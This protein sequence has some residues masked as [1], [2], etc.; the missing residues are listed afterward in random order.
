[1]KNFILLLVLLTIAINQSI[2]QKSKFGKVTKEEL[3]A[4]SH[5]LEEDAKAAIL[6]QEGNH[7]MEYNKSKKQF[8][9]ITEVYKKI[10]IY[11]ATDDSYA[12]VNVSLYTPSKDE[13]NVSSIKAVTYNLEADKVKESKLDKKN[14]FKE[15]VS[16]NRSKTKFALPNVKDGS[17]IEYKYKVTSP[18]VFQVDRW[19][20]QHG[21]PCNETFFR[22]EHPEYYTYRANSTGALPLDVQESQK[23][24]F[25]TFSY[26]RDV[27]NNPNIVKNKFF[28]E[29]VDYQGMITIITQFN[30][31]S[32]QAEKYVTNLNSFRSGISFELESTSWPGQTYQLY[33]QTWDQIAKLLHDDNDFGKQ[34]KHKHK[35]L[36]V[37][38]DQS[39]SKEPAEALVDVYQ[40]IQSNYSYNG[41]IGLGLD[42][43]I[44][45][46]IKTGEGTAS[47]IN[48]LLINTLRKAGVEVYPI[49]TKTRDS[50]VLNT[51]YPILSDLN[52]VYAAAIVDEKTIFLD[53]TDKNILPGQLPL[54]AIN[55]EGIL[56]N[57]EK[58][59]TINITNPNQASI[60]K[61]VDATIDQNLN[62]VCN[63]QQKF[64]GVSANYYRSNFTKAGTVDEW[65]DELET[66]NE[67][68]AY[69]SIE[70]KDGK[71]GSIATTE[72]YTMEGCSESIGE[73]IYI[74]AILGNGI[75]ENPF[76]AER[77]EY[78][79]FYPN[80]STE[81]IIVVVHIPE[82]Y[83]VES[84]PEKAIVSL[85]EKM[86]LFSFTPTALEGKI[87][88]HYSFK[89]NQPTISPTYY[90]AV[91]KFY[92]MAVEKS[93]EKIVFV[94][95]V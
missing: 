93:K 32:I 48:L 78:P 1:M 35:D 29:K 44:K 52:Y 90:E 85:P 3:M 18:Y 39:K 43:G 51:T 5:S 59:I 31:P 2:A 58:G 8:M 86:G 10:K 28:N 21:I 27:S 69:E 63:T 62:L 37:I 4:K 95:K 57:A 60:S 89:I 56:L 79:I 26:T 67:N 53:A 25:V 9:L 84:V 54:R 16:K 94:K 7:Y 91:K 24:R 82:G 87:Q 33:T 30:T 88:I 19:Y 22:F 72:S 47:E 64:G 41:Q 80:K 11:D 40:H 65:M 61:I 81:N 75:S 83:E 46:L 23:S 50:G 70:V 12:N 73:K 17:I 49:V 13:E 6:Y 42:K 36:G 55:L 38:I 14:I 66:S 68:L 20:F 45:S 34:L 71:A 77:R 92:D 74:D 15:K 76:T